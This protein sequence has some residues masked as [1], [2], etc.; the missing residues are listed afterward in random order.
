M[1]LAARRLAEASIKKGA[2]MASLVQT[3]GFARDRGVERRTGN[4]I[5]LK[6]PREAD[7]QGVV[8]WAI[9]SV[10]EAEHR[11]T[12][13]QARIAYLEGLSV[14]D[15]LT[16][17]LNRRGFLS[18]LERALAAARR[19]GPHGVLMV[20]DLDGFKAINDRH[21]HLVGDQVLC[22]VGSLLTRQVRRTDIVARL[23]GDE[24]SILLIGADLQA[25]RRKAQALAQLIS[26]T[27]FA[28][29]TGQVALRVSFGLAAYCGEASEDELM[30]RA[31]MAM[32]GQKRRHA[33]A[34]AVGA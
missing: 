20:S 28:V 34:L 33:A 1:A 29:S 19:G 32:Y 31:D 7:R 23:G 24:F 21:G 10:A 30:N 22:Q 11:V 13:L 26:E 6:L 3:N 9:A 14:T 12:A 16:G 15:E 2:E 27:S 8:D 18:H 4:V 5:P 17:L 25:G